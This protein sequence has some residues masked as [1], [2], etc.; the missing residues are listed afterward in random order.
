[1][2]IAETK[3]II[4]DLYSKSQSISDDF[5]K[6]STSIHLI[7]PFFEALG[8]D[9]QT[10]VKTLIDD[11]IADKAFKID[12]V[13]RFYLKVLPHGT[14]IES[15][16]KSIES[17]TSYAYNKGVTWAVATNFKEMRVYNTEAPG[18]SL[19]SMQH[20]SFNESDYVKKFDDYLSD[21]TKHQFSVN[22]LDA[23]AEY[24]GKK[25]KRVP[26]DKQ[27]LKDLLSFR[28]LL[29]TS[30]I[31]N[32]SIKEEDAE[33]AAQKILNRLIFIRSCGDRKIEERHLK[34]SLSDW[35]QDKSKKLIEYLREI[36]AH[37][38]ERYGSTL[39]E[40]HQCD[41][42]MIHDGVL[43]DVINGLYRSKEKAIEYNFAHIEHDS[44][45]KMYENYLGTVQQK[46]DGAYYTPSY[47]SKY[48]CENTIIPYLSK[49][50]VTTIPELIS[51]YENN[52]EELE[53]KIHNIK[54]LDPACGTGEFLIRAVD[55]LLKISKEI[56]KK[57]QDQGQ[58]Q[59]SV[60]KKKSGL[61]TFQ[62]FDMDIENQQLRAIIQNNI[63]G[64][65]MN[66]EAIEIAQLNIFLKL[67]TSSQQLLDL[68]KNLRVGNSIV[69]D[70][71]VDAK[72]F[73]W[74][75]EFPD[76]FDV[77]IGN[78]PY[79]AEIL[80]QYKKYFKDNFVS[81]T[82]RYES[83]FYFI[84]NGISFLM[85]H[86][87]LGFIVPETWLTNVQS[88]KLR[89]F[90]LDNCNIVQIIALP[91]KVFADAT[92]DTCLIIIK[93]E[94]CVEKRLKN[95]IQVIIYD[96]DANVTNIQQQ[97]F[98]SNIFTLQKHWYE[99]SRKLF[100]IYT[101]DKK[102]S[103]VNKIKENTL[104]LGT[105]SDMRRGGFCYRKSTLIKQFGER[106]GCEILEKKLWHSDHQ[107]N[108][109]YKKELLGSDIGNYSFNW[110][111]KKWFKYGK[112]MASYVEPRFFE[113]D[114]IAVQ[115]IRNPK[116]KQRIVATIIRSGNDYYASSGLTSIIIVDEK[117][118][119]EY[120]LSILN[121]NLMNWYFKQFFRDV[122]IKPDDLRELPI[123]EINLKNMKI[124]DDIIILVNQIIK[125]NNEFLIVKNENTR[126]QLVNQINKI[127]NE[128]NNLIYKLYGITDEE[129]AIIESSI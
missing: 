3:K 78:P 59:H 110:K 96:K 115:R 95:K 9:F 122:N 50:D 69:G 90:V 42:L 18:S 11:N 55:V 121:S 126:K 45:G 17:L 66:E 34:A 84:E 112:H 123:K 44:L 77:I 22:V 57:K 89:E 114:Y 67:A 107:I 23:D 71:S 46:K 19:A 26:I 98:L 113:N 106:K 6:K 76:K 64:V 2:N 48:I 87:K 94:R 104:P 51:E 74:E 102:L 7:Q 47:I 82:G 60:K 108:E 109:F 88:K 27:L 25:P 21:L 15:S 53:S 5:D 127:D 79:G 38:N 16:R 1:L 80:E 56:Q 72:A 86:G 116:L 91:Q 49:L 101:N 65:D 120:V 83:Y 124:G 73:D 61:A 118:T 12:G 52:F 111:N 93:K 20:Y 13:T 63:H 28:N 97:E 39:F 99:D 4:Q 33:P 85:E 81:A 119:I 35:K 125:K 31:K 100:N 40:K 70:P 62:T 58:Y 14:S 10:D 75:K 37:F 41:S 54:I 68:S 128:I 92:V 43:E 8:W 117:F 24:F 103:I 105:I 30:I 29:V 32:N 129:K 36:F